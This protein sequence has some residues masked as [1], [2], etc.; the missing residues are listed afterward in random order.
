MQGI[1]EKAG[2]LQALGSLEENDPDADEE[3]DEDVG[4]EDDGKGGEEQGD[5][6]DVDDLA[7]AMAKQV[8]IR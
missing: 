1:L 8:H 3:L 4:G 5:Q 6:A 7:A 2:R